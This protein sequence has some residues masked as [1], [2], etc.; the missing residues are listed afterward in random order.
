ME[1]FEFKKTQENGAEQF[2]SAL[3][4]IKLSGIFNNDYLENSR[5]V[6]FG[7]NPFV[8]E[9]NSSRVAKE[10]EFILSDFMFG[11]RTDFIGMIKKEEFEK[12]ET[13]YLSDRKFTPFY[14]FD[15]MPTYEEFIAHETAHNVFDLEYKKRFGEYV[16]RNGLTEISDDYRVKMKKYIID[17]TAKYYPAFEVEKFDFSRQQICEIYAMLFQREF[18]RR[19]SINSSANE[20]VEEKMQRFAESPENELEK[21]NF[22]NQRNCSMEDFFSENHILSIIVSPL[23][24]KENQKFNDRL[25]IFWS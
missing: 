16:E 21:F 10:N 13:K 5:W 17:L 14:F 1:S 6:E 2:Q 7:N 15:E 8:H 24:E 19:S 20:Q 9:K 25:K 11:K 3:E 4:K 23:I 12:I 22:K 18:C